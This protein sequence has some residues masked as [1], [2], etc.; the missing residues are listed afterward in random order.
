M[1]FSTR[2]K[3][4][5]K[6]LRGAVADPTFVFSL[7]I[8]LTPIILLFVPSI[9]NKHKE[10]NWNAIYEYLTAIPFLAA[11]TAWLTLEL[12]AGWVQSASAVAVLSVSSSRLQHSGS[13]K[14]R[15]KHGENKRD[16]S[17]QKQNQAR[18]IMPSGG[19][20]TRNEHLISRW[21]LCNG[22][23]FHA[24]VDSCRYICSVVHMTCA[25]I[26]CVRVC[27]CV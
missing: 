7:S 24:L 23:F 11:I 16:K 21:Y 17:K 9:H 14:S 25:R 4:L 22:I 13:R 3:S 2:L 27:V 5:A 19:A 15:G 12:I 18:L 26:C 20:L 8:C 1:R 6:H 10:D